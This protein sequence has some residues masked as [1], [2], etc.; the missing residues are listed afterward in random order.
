MDDHG[1]K[2]TD[3]F[4][5]FNFHHYQ[6]WT[7]LRSHLNNIKELFKDELG[8]DVLDDIAIWA[9]ELGTYFRYR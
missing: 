8:D 1:T 2:V 9:T 3:Y 7:T 4:D 6:G 5:I